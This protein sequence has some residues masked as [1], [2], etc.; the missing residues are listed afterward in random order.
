[1]STHTAAPPSPYTL[2]FG[3]LFGETLRIHLRNVLPFSLLGALVLSPWVVL[4]LFGAELLD[5]RSEAQLVVFDVAV[6]ALP[7]ALSPILTGALAYGVVQQRNGQPASFGRVLAEAFRCWRSLATGI[8]V[9][10]RVVLFGLLALAPVL[11]A[12][13][14]LLPWVPAMLIAFV[15]AMPALVEYLR[16]YVALPVVVVEQRGVGSA[17]RRSKE[18]T[19]GS[20]WTILGG[21]FAFGWVMGALGLLSTFAV[22]VFAGQDVTLL[23]VTAVVQQVLGMGLGATLS[24]VCYLQLRH[25]KE[26]VDPEA[27]AAV[28][29]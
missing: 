26:N 10:L 29:E 9:L 7:L 16:L 3:P 22:E 1:M 13:E 27:L 24:A 2:P 4:V 8:L 19:F 11:L 18:L 21:L 6:S 17:I 15:L 25:G 28:F 5:L 23:L 20:K 14:R 12:T